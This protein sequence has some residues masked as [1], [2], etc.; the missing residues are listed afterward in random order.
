MEFITYEN[1]TSKHATVH[2]KG[3]RQVKKHGGM[4]KHGQGDYWDFSTF[5][6][7]DACAQATGFPV[8]H[9]SFCVPQGRPPAAE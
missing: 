1:R 2:V 9:C 3:C 8:K 6:E 7:A 5:A 4:H